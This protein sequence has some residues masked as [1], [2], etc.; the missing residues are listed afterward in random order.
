MALR[1]HG[2]REPVYTIGVASRLL[3]VSPQTLRQ[4]EKEGLLEPARTENNTR[5]YCQEDLVML[6]RILYLMREEGINAAGVKAL[7]AMEAEMTRGRQQPSREEEEEDSALS[8][9]SYPTT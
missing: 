7:L 6:K 8:F 4:L 2:P 3:E 9:I 1:L 5:L